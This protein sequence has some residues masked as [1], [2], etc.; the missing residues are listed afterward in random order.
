M[1]QDP[2]I[3]WKNGSFRQVPWMTGTVQREGAV[4]AAGKFTKHQNYFF[5][6][7]SIVLALR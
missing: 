1:V 7:H 3:I 6:L 2:R 4:R 5:I